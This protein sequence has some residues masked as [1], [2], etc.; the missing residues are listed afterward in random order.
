VLANFISPMHQTLKE[1]P[2]YT[3]RVST[4][5]TVGILENHPELCAA[6]D[7][8]GVNIQPCFPGQRAASKAGAFLKPQLQAAEKVCGS[9]EGY[10]LEDSWPSADKPSGKAVTPAED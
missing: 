3:G 2:G 10:V 5:E 9:N 4:A 7:F 6:V 1:G 8:V